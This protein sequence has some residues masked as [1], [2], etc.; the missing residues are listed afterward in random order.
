MAIPVRTPKEIEKL[1]LANQ[2][3]GKTLRYIQDFVKPNVTLLELDALIEKYI[4]SHGARPAFKGLYGFPNSACI[5]VNEVIIHGIPTAVSYT[6]LT[7][8][9]TVGPCRSRWSPYH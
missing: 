7:L 5:S 3:V 6:H 4:R 2:L 9:T 1:R 8:P